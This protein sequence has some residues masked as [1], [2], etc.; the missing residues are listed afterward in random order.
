MNKIHNPKKCVSN[1]MGHNPFPPKPKTQTNSITT[2]F[3]S[4]FNQIWAI[5]SPLKPIYLSSFYYFIQTKKK[6]FILFS[7]FDNNIINIFYYN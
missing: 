4:V 3:V 5:E 7:P 6:N 2:P 1:E